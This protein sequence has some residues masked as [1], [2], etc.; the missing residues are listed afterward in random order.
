MESC[1]WWGLCQTSFIAKR[2]DFIQR[3]EMDKHNG[4]A[5]LKHTVDILS[6]ENMCK[7]DFLP[8]Q[9]SSHHENPSLV[10]FWW[11][12]WDKE[13]RKVSDQTMLR[14]AKKMTIQKGIRG[15]PAILKTT[16]AEGMDIAILCQFCNEKD[17]AGTVMTK[18]TFHWVLP[19]GRFYIVLSQS[20]QHFCM[21]IDM[22]PIFKMRR[23]KI[24]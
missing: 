24:F 7:A 12:F 22:I 10:T 16:V 18:A 11:V 15:R 23:L 5:K 3:S 2:R 14:C 9:L 13:V 20:I 19:R 6:V 17:K 21:V 8:W 1:E 4:Q